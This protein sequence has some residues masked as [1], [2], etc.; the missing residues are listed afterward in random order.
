[1]PDAGK[2][3]RDGYIMSESTND[4]THRLLIIDDNRDIHK[5][6]KK[7]LACENDTEVLDAL[8]AELFG[9]ETQAKE[10]SSFLI[11]SAFQG[12]EGLRLLQCA[13]DE[14]NPYSLAIVD[15]RM[16]PGWDGI[17]TIH[18]LWEVDPNLQI[19]ICTAYSDHSWDDIVSKLDPGDRLLILKKPFD[20]VEILQMVNTLSKKR[21]LHEQLVQTSEKRYQILYDDNP[22]ILFTLSQAGKIISTNRYGA[23]HLG[24]SVEELIGKSAADLYQKEDWPSVKQHFAECFR[25]K[26]RVHQWETSKRRKDHSLIWARETGRVVDD[27]RYG[28]SLLLVCEDITRSHDLYEKLSYDASHDVLTRLYNRRAFEHHVARLLT[29]HQDGE[30]SYSICYIDL[31]RFKIINDTCGHAAG[32]ELLRQVGELFRKHVRKGDI[33]ARLGGDEFGLLMEACPPAI[34][35][36]KAEGILRDVQDFHFLWQDKS[37]NIGASIGL[38]PITESLHSIDEILTAADTACYIAKEQG[39]NRIHIS[40][41]GDPERSRRYNEI[42]WIRRINDALEHDLFTLY[43]QPIIPLTATLD[44]GYHYELLLRLTGADGSIIAPGTFLPY[45]ERYNLASQ[46]DQWVVTK[47]LRWLSQKPQHVQQLSMC[48]I[49]LSG[50]SVVDS[51]FLE[52]L[53]SALKQHHGLAPKICFEITETAAIANLTT[54]TTFIE[55]LS[56]Y[57]CRFALDDFGSGASSFAYLK[58]FP[59]NMLKIDGMFVKDIVDD[60]VSFAIVKSTNEVAKVMGRQTIAEFVSSQSILDKLRELDVDYAQGFHI[61][62]PAP[63][64]SMESSASRTGS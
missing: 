7:I 57:G 49:N 45:A 27:P 13:L 21:Q 36:R 37:F 14:D 56:A 51:Q 23:E 5:D 40:V 62:K 41:D 16:P 52:F 8:E 61:A 53:D 15:M 43:Y 44:E 33:L 19:I 46:I 12:K 22:A 42:E 39:R 31:D 25:S 26:D 63:L 20:N 48:A 17:D 55:K 58:T 24:Y 29:Q 32:D 47:A 54:A 64:V 60:R 10:A 9:L 50:R 1:M 3:I 6:I 35:E 4:G 2:T 38:V 28:L 30:G 18:H 11:D 59:V 34:A